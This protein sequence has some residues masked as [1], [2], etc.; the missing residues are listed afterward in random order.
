M[1]E[2]NIERLISAIKSHFSFDNNIIDLEK[3]LIDN[4]LDEF[5][6]VYISSEVIWW[7]YQE[8]LKRSS[9]TNFNLD[10]KEF[11][12]INQELNFYLYQN[13]IFNETDLDILL[14]NAINLKINYLLRPFHTLI[15]FIYRT[16]L[17]KPLS[18]ISLRLNYFLREDFLINF[19]RQHFSNNFARDDYDFSSLNQFYFD[20]YPDKNISRFE[21]INILNKA[22]IHLMSNL[23]IESIFNPFFELNKILNKNDSSNEFEIPIEAIL[24][25]CND[26]EFKNLQ[27]YF[28]NL[29]IN[30]NITTLKIDEFRRNIESFIK[31][32]NQS[33]INIIPDNRLNY[34]NSSME[35]DS[36]L[37]KIS[38]SKDSLIEPLTN[39]EFEL[40]V[41]PDRAELIRVANK[42]KNELNKLISTN[43]EHD[44]DNSEI[45]SAASEISKYLTNLSNKSEFEKYLVKP[46]DLK[47]CD[48]DEIIIFSNEINEHTLDYEFNTHFNDQRSQLK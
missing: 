40:F 39:D 2:K 26:F 31:Q 43:N 46:S 35:K 48:I 28:E 4:Q 24:I 36:P 45:I 29:C 15:W 18:E 42:V 33:H 9:L 22:K 44:E 19:I 32:L 25:Y 12:K 3:I 10:N 21:F 13:T 38:L 37:A 30:Q 34:A 8:D 6:K 27:V 20:F 1:F 7:I 5:Y 16:E 11:K 23:S 41:Q 47:I 14:K 17:Q